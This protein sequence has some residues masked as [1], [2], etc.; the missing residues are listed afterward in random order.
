[1]IRGFVTIALG[2]ALLVMGT[3]PAQA[4]SAAPRTDAE[5]QSA[6]RSAVAPP[7]PAPDATP[8]HGGR[9]VSDTRE[10]AVARALRRGP[11][12]PH[13]FREQVRPEARV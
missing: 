7:A 8:A 9:E 13:P 1:M 4:S 6:D 12:L 3:V 5:R 2:G 11:A 10:A